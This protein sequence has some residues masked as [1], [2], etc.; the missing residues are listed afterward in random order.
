ML[1]RCRASVLRCGPGIGTSANAV[2]LRLTPKVNNTAVVTS[3]QER[4]TRTRELVLTVAAEEF[5]ERGLWGARV[6]R[7]LERAQLTKGALYH[8]FPG[9]EDLAKELVRV[10]TE[11]WR[12]ELAARAESSGLVAFREV[13]R[14]VI[15]RLLG[16]VRARAA[17]RVFP[18]LRDSGGDAADVPDPVLAWREAIARSLEEAVRDGEVDAELRVR[19]T[20]VMTAAFLYGAA[21]TPDP[22]LAQL[23]AEARAAAVQSI[24]AAGI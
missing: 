22:L 24:L 9:K 5:W 16:D 2:H 11:G 3:R 20:S 15:V 4:A 8:H 6:D 10:E 19:H 12:T 1:E 21:L 17:L 7:I 14:V 18:E 13:C 23:D